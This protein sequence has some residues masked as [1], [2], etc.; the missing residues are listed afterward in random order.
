MKEPIPY[1]GVA[2]P[3]IPGRT[4]GIVAFVLSF[5][6]Q[7]IALIL[8]LIALSQSRKAGVSN[9]FAIAGVVISAVL[10]VGGIIVTIII[11]SLGYGTPSTVTHAAA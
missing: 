1:N 8:G 11:L 5:F 10:I 9:S 6:L 7:L 3:E 2:A 4:L